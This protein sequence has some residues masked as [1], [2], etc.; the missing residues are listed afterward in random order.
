[1]GTLEE[2]DVDGVSAGLDVA[3][4]YGRET[5]F[6]TVS[7][8]IEC[9]DINCDQL[10]L[11]TTSGGISG[12]NCTASKLD[13]DSVSGGADLAGAFE[14][15]N[16]ETVSGGVRLDCTTAPEKIDGDSVS[17]TITVSLPEGSGFVVELETVS[18]E[19]SCDFAGT[20]SGDKITC[21][22]GSGSYQLNSVSGGVRIE[23][24]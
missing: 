18:G 20:M 3:G 13:I 15:V 4:V 23:Q 10:N 11:S 21:G 5:S 8:G 2:L 9:A 17:G 22:D 19:I 12:E 7:G 16:I 1:M 14:K 24:N 6:G